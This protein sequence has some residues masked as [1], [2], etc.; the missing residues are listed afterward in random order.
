[1][2]QELPAVAG[3]AIDARPEPAPAE[4]VELTPVAEAQRLDVLDVLAECVEPKLDAYVARDGARGRF[5]AA[6]WPRGRV[7]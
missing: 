5:D 2:T 4:P 3:D 7:G 6:Q 1:M